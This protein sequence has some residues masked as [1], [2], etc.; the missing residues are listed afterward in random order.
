MSQSQKMPHLHFRN[1]REVA[2]YPKERSNILFE[3][4]Y[5]TIGPALGLSYVMLLANQTRLSLYQQANLF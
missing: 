5:S 1:T 4:N 2:N 3:S